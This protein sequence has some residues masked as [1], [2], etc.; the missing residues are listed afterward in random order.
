MCVTKNQYLEQA[1]KYLS[2][3]FGD[4]IITRK[5]ETKL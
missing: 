5:K 3:F 1:I 2:F 4:K